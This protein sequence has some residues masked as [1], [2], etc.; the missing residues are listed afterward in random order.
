MFGV[1][2]C[3]VILADILLLIQGLNVEQRKRL[4]IAVELV[5]LPE[6]LVFLGKPQNPDRHRPP[7]VTN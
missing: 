7:C 4:S 6:L 1:V 5:T 3:I 2:Q